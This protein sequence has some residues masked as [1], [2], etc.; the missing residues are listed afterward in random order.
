VNGWLIAATALLVGVGGAG[1]VV[2]RRSLMH[3]LVALELA[4]VLATLTAV[5]LAEGFH[6][7]PFM[8]LAIVLGLMSVTGALAFARML[9]RWV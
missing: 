4:G 5:V 9:G 6:R 2:A 8:D 1:W 3:A 7:K